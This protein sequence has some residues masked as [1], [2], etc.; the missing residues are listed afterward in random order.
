VR[1]LVSDPARSG[2]FSVWGPLLDGTR[3]L[4]QEEFHWEAKSA[5]LDVAERC[6]RP[7]LNS[8]RLSKRKAQRFLADG[9]PASERTSASRVST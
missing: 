1:D 7:R 2:A 8:K 5:V 4:A 6:L 9:G 3:A